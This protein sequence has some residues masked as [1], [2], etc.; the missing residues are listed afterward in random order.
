M[1]SKFA[2]TGWLIVLESE[3]SRTLE[4]QSE[5]HDRSSLPEAITK[6][7]KMIKNNHLGILEI[8]QRGTTNWEVCLQEKLLSIR[9]E[10]WEFITSCLGHLPPWDPVLLAGSS[11]RV[12]VVQSPS[13]VWLFKTPWTT[14][15][16]SYKIAPSL[17][18]GTNWIWSRTQRKPNAQGF[19]K[20]TATIFS[21]SISPSVVSDPL[22]LYSPSGFSW[23]I[24]GKNVGVGCHALLQGIF[25]SQGSKLG[26]LDCK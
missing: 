18:E 9:Y 7:N 4:W 23:T 11:T 1:T 24:P 25:P 17:P 8:E 19:V 3:G 14:A 20:K 15:W 5:E 21:F 10:Q 16:L 2:R 12:L 26:L 13:P 22:W 6:L